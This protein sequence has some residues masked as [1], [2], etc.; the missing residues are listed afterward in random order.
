MVTKMIDLN[1]YVRALREG[2]DYVDTTFK[3]D[4][5][6]SERQA[7]RQRWKAMTAEELLHES[8]RHLSQA[9]EF[10][11]NE[12]Y[13]S[14][15]AESLLEL[16]IQPPGTIIIHKTSGQKAVILNWNIQPTLRTPYNKAYIRATSRAD[17]DLYYLIEAGWTV[18]S[19]WNNL[20]GKP[21]VKWSK[22]Q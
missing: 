8:Q 20:D 12:I 10:D 5:M 13:W 22:V 3:L 7:H 18:Y 21:L 4:R 6:T 15:V 1:E 2:V 16:D 9:E 19:L 14:K 11:L 17:W